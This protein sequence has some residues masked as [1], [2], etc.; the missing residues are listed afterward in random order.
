MLL[1]D[2][3]RSS[4]LPAALAAALAADGARLRVS[5]LSGSLAAALAAAVF[6]ADSRSVHLLVAPDKDEAYY[7]A[8]DLET[9]LDDTALAPDSKRVHIF[10]ATRRRPYSVHDD[11]ETSVDSSVELR[12][13][14][15][16]RQLATGRPLLVVT[17]PDALAEKVV[18]SRTLTRHTLQFARGGRLDLDRVVELM[19]DYRFERVDFVVEPGQY[20]IRGGIVDIYSFGSDMPFRIEL[21]DDTIDSLRSFDPVSQLSARHHDSVNIVPRLGADAAD[22]VT[23]TEHVSLLAYLGAADVVW[24]HNLMSVAERLDKLH[25]DACARHAAHTAPVARLAPDLLYSDSSDFLHQLLRC[26]IVELGGSGYFT[27]ALRFEAH[28]EPQPRFN[29]QFD[30]LSRSLSDYRDRGFR[31]LITVSG[32]QQRRRLEKVLPSDGLDIVNGQLSGGFVDHDARLLCFTDHQIFERFHK[33]TVRD[34]RQNREALTL[35]DLAELKPGDFVTHI[36][37]GVGRF[38]GLE[39]ITT[40]GHTQEVIRLLYK[41]NDTLYISIHGLHKI[42]RYIGKDGV[43]PVLDR[44]GGNS[45]QLLKQRTKRQVKDIAKDLIALYAKRMASRGF[46]FSPDS[47][48]Q[49]EL[50]ASFFYEDTPDQQRATVDVKHDME[51]TAPM[52]RLVCGDVGFGKTEVAIRAAFKAVADSKQ[53]AVLVPSTILAFQHYNTFSERLQGMPVRVDYLNR[54]RTARERAAL[55]RDLEAG[56]IDILI[57]THAITGKSVRFKDLG[58]LI[59]DEEQKFG[60]AVK[61]RLRQLKVNVDCLTLTATPIPRTLQFSLMG[62]RDLSVIQTPPPNR[63][64]VETEVTTFSEELIRDAVM[65]EMSRGGQTFFVSNRVENMD[66][67]AALVLRLVPDARVAVAHGR[68]DGKAVEDTLMRFLSGDLDVLVATSIVEN[69]LDIPNANTIIVNNAHH[70]GLSDL[71]QLRGRVGRSNQ[72]AF[73]YMLIPSYSLLTPEA[74]K[75]L[76]AIEEFGSVGSGFNI[77]MRDLDI[78]GAGNIL[79]AEQSGFISEIGYDMYQKILAEAIDELK[80]SDFRDLFVGQPGAPQQYVRD[81]T[82]ET[83]L[84]VLIP[85][86]YVTSISERLL[87]YRQISEL[88]SDDDVDRFRDHL[89]D[90]FGPLPDPTRELLLTV[91][92]R[93]CAKAFGVERLVLKND[94]LTLH[95]PSDQQNPFYQSSHF[96][97]LIAY[98]QRHAATSRLREKDSGLTLRCA[99]IQSVRQALEIIQELNPESP[100][101][102]TA[103]PRSLPAA[104]GAA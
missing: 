25:A 42:S 56:R 79:G 24:L 50:E 52:D 85:D 58:L 98:A 84:E 22:T 17:Y 65:Y 39:K 78:R 81:C 53:V 14:E 102:S 77:A 10:P 66:E 40:N 19:Q 33:Y 48:L 74:Q 35:K 47:Y 54:F 8:N 55:L 69:G 92:L 82:V 29:K 104:P 87:L 72:K 94:A 100:G 61:E 1:L 67:M 89:V 51:A 36:D 90:R 71:H 30:L 3:Y 63:Q 4:A 20:A 16:I 13:T 64:P 96:Q 23:C 9:L 28:A 45:W 75:R 26:R 12:R 76:R 103:K 99:A 7:L 32:D 44:L 2:H 95:F 97:R 73:C 38:S 49:T 37:Y 91:A 11:D 68:M 43:A 60:V 31:I 27:D 101:A 88:T 18:S 6:S 70:F 83:D 59:I 93:R 80:Q 46:A 41:N 21:F 86:D 57:G 62:A 15:V 5:G 34:L